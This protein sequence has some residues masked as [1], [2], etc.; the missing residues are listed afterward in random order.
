MS[1]E[2]RLLS[3]AVWSKAIGAREKPKRLSLLSDEEG[4]FTCPISSCDSEKFFSQR[5]CRKH[6]YSKHAWFYFFDEKP[7][8]A[9]VLPQY[10]KR[11][12]PPHKKRGS[13]R[14]MPSFH[15]TCQIFREFTSWLSSYVG[16]NKSFG[17][18][19]QIG[20]KLLKYVKYACNDVPQGH[21]VEFKT[22]DYV[23]GSPETIS[24]FVNHLE[25]TWKVGY[26]G[27]LGYLNALSHAIDYRRSL[28]VA[29]CTMQ[30]FVMS[31]IYLQ[32]I[33]R[34][35]G[36]KMRVQ[37]KTVLSIEYLESVNC[38]ATLEDL[39]NV[40]PF[41]KDRF[42]QVLRNATNSCAT[43][44][45]LS[46]ATSF[47]VTVLFLM[48]KATRP[49]TFQYL[50]VQM[51]KSIDCNGFIDQT[52]FK[53]NET[54]GFDTLLFT[55]EIQNFINC[56][57]ANIRTLLNP[58]CD[59]VLVTRNGAQLPKLTEH[60]GNLVYQA[61]GKYIHPTRYRQIVETE[62]TQKLSLEEQKSLSQDQKHSSV[63]AQ[64]HYQKVRSQAVAK[65]GSR[66]MEKL[67][68]F[69]ASRSALKS[70]G[71]NLPEVL[72]T[73]LS[74][75]PK[76]ETPVQ[77]NTACSDTVIDKKATTLRKMKVPFSKE[78]D[79]FIAA[80]IKRYGKGRWTSILKDPEFTFNES[81]QISTL[82]VRAKTLNLI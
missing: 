39:Q 77:N 62:S 11:D 76:K 2:R 16:G 78:E 33:K 38:W 23:L 52:I 57:I 20:S 35:L 61:I 66:C 75:T 18:A 34:T 47:V 19:N 29:Y 1:R 13:T 45:Q 27:I 40:V 54:Y 60:F 24:G 36:K 72:D 9:M 48:V 80:G 58:K 42:I 73:S 82:S 49:M 70:I 32:R 28:G 41:H 25:Q 56:Y 53:T 71:L 74:N 55:L 43:E 15:K 5:G 12:S 64:V 65:E 51:V 68:D 63:V 6:V 17:Q 30:A 21:D 3:K 81:R 50:T 44:F 59:Y 7:I 8:L 69:H 4:K 26:P 79:A 46:F 22:I 67:V 10:S 14:D 31:E 37:W